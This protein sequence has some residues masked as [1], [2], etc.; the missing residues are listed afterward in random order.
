[1]FLLDFWLNGITL[2]V[3][4]FSYFGTILSLSVFIFVV[5]VMIALKQVLDNKKQHLLW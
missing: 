3:Q 1:M 5:Y 4:P 2:G